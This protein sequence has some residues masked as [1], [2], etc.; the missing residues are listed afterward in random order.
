MMTQGV[1]LTNMLFNH[2]PGSILE[3][4]TG[5]V[6]IKSWRAMI[7]NLEQEG[8]RSDGPQ[9]SSL[10]W[11]RQLEVDEPRLSS[12]LIRDEAKQIRLHSLPSNKSMQGIRHQAKLVESVDFPIWY[13]CRKGGN[14]PNH[15]VLYKH[16][17]R[18]QCLVCN[19]TERSSA[20]RFTGA[21]NGGH[22]FDL[23]W[24]SMVHKGKSECKLNAFKWEER[25]TSTSGIRISCLECSVSTTMSEATQKIKSW[26]CTRGDPSGVLPEVDVCD[27]SMSV[28]LRS[29]TS[30]W[31]S[32]SIT[33]ITIADDEIKLCLK[34]MQKCHVNFDPQNVLGQP[35]PP[36]PSPSALCA[37]PQWDPMTMSMN[38]VPFEEGQGSHAR[39]DQQSWMLMYHLS[40]YNLAKDSSY[41][42]K[43]TLDVFKRQIEP[44]MKKIDQSEIIASVFLE[45]W[46]SII[47][48]RRVSASE[49][50]TSEFSAMFGSEEPIEWPSKNLPWFK[51][52]GRL[53]DVHG[54]QIPFTFGADSSKVNL[55]I[56]EVTKL[57]AVTALRGFSR[58]VYDANGNPARSVPLGNRYESGEEWYA[59]VEAQGEGILIT[60][61]GDSTLSK[62]GSQWAKWQQKHVDYLT[63]PPSNRFNFR[64]LRRESLDFV[65]SEQHVVEA[66][67]MFVWWHTLAHHLIRAIQ[68]DTGY[69]SSAIRE[70]VYAEK[71]GD[72]WTGGILLYVTEGG[73]DGTLGGLTS[74]AINMQRYLD[75]IAG[76][77]DQCSNDPLCTDTTSSSLP[78][79]RGCYSCT[80][81]SE[82]SCGHRN[83]FVDRLLMREGV[84]LQ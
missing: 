29:S 25:S 53:T 14:H 17:S 16:D 15:A 62:V 33:A 35:P 46:K 20:I 23:P 68:Q 61:D 13:L 41:A 31:Q 49:S 71:Q 79:D 44:V 6:V 4:I 73:M 43:I 28:V 36:M 81:N 70:R 80:Y 2:G 66:H 65:P 83:L 32:D 38:E 37:I 52:S 59:A 50:M 63:K 24:Y 27:R 26:A 12:Q 30:L 55:R 3:T 67:P 7:A 57:R 54:A 84:G 51:R 8:N 74:L 77:S 60:F 76:K 5:P 72:S 34:A 19:D 18:G 40:K 78:E 64:G 82:T 75:I 47:N 10:E 56:H 9:L 58:P 11:L 69:S 21:C 48:P 22:L 1:R 45:E 39:Q 42:G